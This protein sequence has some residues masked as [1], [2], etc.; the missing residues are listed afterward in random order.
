MCAAIDYA[1][2]VFVVH[3]HRCK[4]DNAL[5]A[6]DFPQESQVQNHVYSTV[7]PTSGDFM[8]LQYVMGKQEEDVYEDMTL[9]YRRYQ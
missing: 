1:Q 9:T 3:C 6:P 2:C 7:L 4:L 8:P 5:V